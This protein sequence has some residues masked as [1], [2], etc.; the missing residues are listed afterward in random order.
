MSAKQTMG[1]TAYKLTCQWYHHSKWQMHS[2]RIVFSGTEM[3][4]GEAVLST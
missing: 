3:L 2:G 4:G 1:V